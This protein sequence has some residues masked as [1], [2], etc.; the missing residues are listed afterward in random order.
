MGGVP[1]LTSI[2]F[3]SDAQLGYI[4]LSCVRLDF[5]RSFTGD[6][7]LGHPMAFPK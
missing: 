2:E 5:V 3:W 4:D 7:F 1:V 6:P